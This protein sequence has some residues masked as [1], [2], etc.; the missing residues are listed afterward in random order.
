MPRQVEPSRTVTLPVVPPQAAPAKP[1]QLP[2]EAQM[3][4][5]GAA[6]Q[7]AP[8]TTSQPKAAGDGAPTPAN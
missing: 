5:R 8:G 3:F 4:L 2:P 7:A 6:P 1:S